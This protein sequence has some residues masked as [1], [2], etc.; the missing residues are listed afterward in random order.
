M[1]GIYNVDNSNGVPYPDGMRPVKN[2]SPAVNA[3][4]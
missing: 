3:W 2:A 4:I 1:L